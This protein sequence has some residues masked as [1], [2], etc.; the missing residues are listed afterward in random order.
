MVTD[1]AAPREHVHT[2]LR[3]MLGRAR[4]LSLLVLLVVLAMCF[5][6]SWTT[7]DAMVHLPFLKGQKPQ[8]DLAASSQTTIV[9]LHPWQIA[10]ALTPLAVSREEVE[11]AHEAERLADH[12]VNQ[13][14]ATSLRQA[15]APHVAPT[16]EAVELSQK[17][18]QLQQT[19]KDDQGRVRSLTPARRRTRQCRRRRRPENRPGATGS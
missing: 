6:F 7:R 15:G 19:V 11:Y 4:F 9:D 16:G 13:A 2:A 3:R 1:L 10:Q 8:H 12:E 17:V 5:G 14:F 18:T